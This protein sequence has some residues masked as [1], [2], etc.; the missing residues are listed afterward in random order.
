MDEVKKVEKDPIK[1][2]YTQ[3][4]GFFKKIQ[5][6]YNDYKEKLK[7]NKSVK[8]DLDSVLGILLIV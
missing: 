1:D 5:I 2:K 4:T 8:Q 3:K 6:K 7:N